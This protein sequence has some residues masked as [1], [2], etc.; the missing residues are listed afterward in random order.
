MHLK[1]FEELYPFHRIFNP[2]MTIEPTPKTI[3][4][5]IACCDGTWMDSDKGYQEPGLFEKEGSLQIPSNVTR[6]SRCFEKRCSDGKLQVVNYESG[7]GTGSNMLD[8]ITGGA[9]GQG[10]AEVC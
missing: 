6:I 10:L 7:V 9:F 4:R 2:N 3:K 5:L 1:L 8:S